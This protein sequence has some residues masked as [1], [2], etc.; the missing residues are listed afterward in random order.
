MKKKLF[1][2]MLP[3]ISL[4]LVAVMSLTGVTYAWFTSGKTATVESFDVNVKAIDGI[5]IS[6]SGFNGEWG[7]YIDPR[8]APT[9]TNGVVSTVSTS[10][11]LRDVSS[12]GVI[13]ADAEHS[14]KDGKLQFFTAEYN[15]HGKTLSKTADVT[16]Y[17]TSTG[18]GTATESN[19]VYFEFYVKNENLDQDAGAKKINLA[20]SVVTGSALSRAACRVA[21][22]KIG[23][24]NANAVLNDNTAPKVT[25]TPTLMFIWE[26]N[27]TEHSPDGVAYMV[28]NNVIAA[29][30]DSGVKVAYKAVDKAVGT[31]GKFYNT[32]DG[33]NFKTATAPD[34]DGTLTGYYVIG[35]DGFRA[36]TVDDYYKVVSFDIAMADVA[37]GKVY[38]K[39]ASG[40]TVATAPV[41][42]GETYFEAQT[43]TAYQKDANDNLL[44]DSAIVTLNEAEIANA[45]GLFTLG[46]NKIV[47]IGVYVW[48]EGQD[49]DTTNY[50]AGNPFQVSIKL[51]K[52]GQ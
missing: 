32:F 49:A 11:P 46:A 43:V 22:V 39:G 37:S 5:L 18:T 16:G 17:P 24:C 34:V 14:I 28:A 6:L 27:S 38:V 47:K 10:L 36:L 7:S 12:N 25:G 41:V 13:Y 3:T 8:T 31:D 33:Q 29:N 44:T 9:D 35:D 45:N 51:N 50:V 20:N 21:F 4:L 26:P 40:Y 2:A 30:G 42:Q 1:K 19:Y 23:E 48:I 15:E 52:V